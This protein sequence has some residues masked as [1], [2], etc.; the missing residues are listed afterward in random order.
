MDKRGVNINKEAVDQFFLEG[1]RAKAIQGLIECEEFDRIV[2]KAFDQLVA[3][4]KKEKRTAPKKVAKRMENQLAKYKIRGKEIF[5]YDAIQTLKLNLYAQIMLGIGTAEEADFARKQL[6]ELENGNHDMAI[7]KIQ[8]ICDEMVRIIPLEFFNAVRN[9]MI[10][11]AISQYGLKIL[12]GNFGDYDRSI[13]YLDEKLM[14]RDSKEE[15]LKIIIGE[16]P[17]KTTYNPK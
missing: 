9:S 15:G 1:D 7:T 12:S 17:E 11:E 16:T 13:R 4:Y 5:G 3:F 6:S 14:Q 8:G 2:G 10:E